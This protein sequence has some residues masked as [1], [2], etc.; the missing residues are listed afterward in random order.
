MQVKAYL[1]L[2]NEGTFVST[3]TKIFDSMGA[4]YTWLN[5]QDDHPYLSY[6]LDRVE[7]VYEPS[8]N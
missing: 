4:M 1:T 5:R 7:E 3:H 2:L 6:N 8:S